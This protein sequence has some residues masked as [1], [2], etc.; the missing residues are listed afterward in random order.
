MSKR[1]NT[2]GDQV[3]LKR[4]KAKGYPVINPVN[5][6]VKISR[7][8]T[9]SGCTVS[10]LQE[11][12]GFNHPTSIYRWQNGEAVPRVDNLIALAEF[13]ECTID[14]LVCYDMVST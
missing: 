3:A 7:Y 5:T 6:G 8:L 12:L 11:Y 9:D 10:D 13:F 4:I 1:R 14:D 2:K